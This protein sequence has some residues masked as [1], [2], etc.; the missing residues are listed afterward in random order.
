MPRS[1]E[2]WATQL[3]CHDKTLPLAKRAALAGERLDVDGSFAPLAF[4]LEFCE[5]ILATVAPT[6][7]LLQVLARRSH[8]GLGTFNACAEAGKQRPQAL[9]SGPGVSRLK[10]AR[11]IEPAPTSLRGD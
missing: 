9:T 11:R 3:S 4:A 1:D 5:G 7:R 10:P 8:G 6:Q 2:R